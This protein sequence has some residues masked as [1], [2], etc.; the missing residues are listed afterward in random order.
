LHFVVVV[1]AELFEQLDRLADDVAAAAGA[2][3]RAAR[4]DAV[5]AELARED[6]L[7]ALD[8]FGLELVLREHF[9]HGRD[10]RSRHVNVESCLGSH[11][12]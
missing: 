6:D 1:D 10:Q 2:G 9:D 12:T 8:L 3:R 5:D 7:V 4:L 11:P